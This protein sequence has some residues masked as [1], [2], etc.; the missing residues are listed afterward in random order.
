MTRLLLEDSI[1]PLALIVKLLA[2]IKFGVATAPE[3]VP[4]IVL[5]TSNVFAVLDTKI[6]SDPFAPITAA[7]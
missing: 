7:E 1:I 2:A 6:R 4:T 5:D 3:N